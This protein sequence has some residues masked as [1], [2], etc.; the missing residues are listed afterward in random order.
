MRKIDVNSV[1]TINDNEIAGVKNSYG[2][3]FLKI[4]VPAKF[5]F[6][7][8]VRFGFVLLYMAM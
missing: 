4:S 7:R 1:K 2:R 8:F 6:V 3:I 5:G